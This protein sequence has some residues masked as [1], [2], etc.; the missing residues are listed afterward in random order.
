MAAGRHRRTK[1]AQT[2]M[3][4]RIR[5]ACRFFQ[6][7]L[8]AADH[9]V[10]CRNGCASVRLQRRAERRC[11]GTHLGGPEPA[12][13]RTRTGV[14]ACGMPILTSDPVN[15]RIVLASRP[16]AEP[17]EESFRLETV[18]VESPGDG[19]ILV[20][21]QFLSLDPYMR[22]RMSDRPSYAPPVALGAVMVGGTVG[23]VVESCSTHFERGDFVVGY[24][25]WQDYARLRADD[26]KMQRLMRV[27]NGPDDPPV[28][29]ALGVAGMPGCT[30]L[31]GLT[32]LGK[33]RNGETLVVSAASGAVGSIVGQIGK[34][35]GCHVVGIAGGPEKCHYCV[36][37]LGFD[38]CV[39]YKSDEF[40]AK[41]EAACPR[42]V[43]IYFENVGGPVSRAVAARFNPGAR[44][45][46]CGFIS[47]YN[48]EAPAWP[49]QIFD[50]APNPPE[51]RM[52]LVWEWPDEY[53]SAVE[54]LRE[55]VRS[56]QLKYR[57]DVVDGLE[58]A[59]RAFQRLFSGRNFGKLLVRL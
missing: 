11:S 38:T 13:G 39:D 53:S 9:E 36:A 43:D 18:P 51:Y 50:E 34:V 47:Q 32:K 26:A 19:E 42:G 15:R 1:L 8:A 4:E 56:G 46:I 2:P 40:E 14:G 57:E 45:P 30:A 58:N 35:H 10:I 20:R 7:V 48:A 28:Q 55:W 24:G 59:P 3:V 23:E 49:G 12:V 17:T 22:G 44:A 27:P 37:E 41:L 31:L 29:T 54:R 16:P 5:R 33:P 6:P 52:F 25:G 21:N